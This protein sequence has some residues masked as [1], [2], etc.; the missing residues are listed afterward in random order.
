MSH[1]A[2]Q[3]PA[4]LVYIPV[5]LLVFCVV[6][7]PGEDV[8]R[9]ALIGDGDVALCGQA[10]LHQV[11]VSVCENGPEFKSEYHV[12]HLVV[13]DG[14]EG[15][16]AQDVQLWGYQRVIQVG[17]ITDHL[18]TLESDLRVCMLRTVGH[19]RDQ[20]LPFFV[21]LH[22]ESNEFERVPQRTDGDGFD[23]GRGLGAAETSHYGSQDLIDFLLG[24]QVFWDFLAGVAQSH[25]R[26]LLEI[27]VYVGR[28][29]NQ[30][31]QHVWPFAVREVYPN[32]RG[33]E[34][35]C[36][37]ANPLVRGCEHAQSLLTHRGF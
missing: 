13:L 23:G 22:V 8:I 20:V 16:R 34:L 17:H 5:I 3:R 30:N 12:P 11:F 1:R 36:A 25:N 31:V 19:G 37:A 26:R 24:Q 6:V 33:Y 21:V 7:D 28:I 15:S 2:D 27:W 4:S 35:G 14:I 10:A 29:R 18:E 32:N 9:E